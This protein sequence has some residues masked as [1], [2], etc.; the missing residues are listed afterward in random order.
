[1]AAN[2]QQIKCNVTECHFNKN[3]LCDAPM[4]QVDRNGVGRASQ[5]PQTKCETFKPRS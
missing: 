3:V 1:M 2:C 4:I 5:S